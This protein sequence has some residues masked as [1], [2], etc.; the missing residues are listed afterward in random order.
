MLLNFQEFK[1]AAEQVEKI[2]LLPKNADLKMALINSS[3]GIDKTKKREFYQHMNS[4]FLNIILNRLDELGTQ[5]EEK[6]MD[7][8]KIIISLINTP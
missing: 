7:A 8:R 2:I 6:A 5:A 4:L 1:T 3:I